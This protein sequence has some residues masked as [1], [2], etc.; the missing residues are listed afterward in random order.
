VSVNVVTNSTGKSGGGGGFGLLPL[1][2]LM[3][4]FRRRFLVPKR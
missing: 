2:C 3:F 4:S 1:L